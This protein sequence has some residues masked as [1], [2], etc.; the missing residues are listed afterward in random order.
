MINNISMRILFL[1]LTLAITIGSCKTAGTAISS[2]DISIGVSCGMCRGECFKGYRVKGGVVEHFAAPYLGKMDSARIEK[3]TPT[4]EK[5]FRE[6]VSLLPVLDNYP[7]RIGCPDCHD[8]CG[9]Q[10]STASKTIMID[11][12]DYPAEFNK[13][14]QKLRE[15][16]IL[17]RR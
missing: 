13:F 1:S 8:Q 14:M 10:V 7:E 2:N 6:L 5:D 9:V 3:A 17:G 11:P 4:Q 12:A 16:E 15:M